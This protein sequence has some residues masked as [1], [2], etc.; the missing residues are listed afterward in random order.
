MGGVIVADEVGLGKTFVAGEILQLYRER[1]QRAVLICPAALRDS[2]WRRFLIT[3]QLFVECLSFEQLANDVQLRD[4]QR[5]NA[6]RRAPSA[7]AGRSTN[8]SSSTRPTTTAI[9]TRPPGPLRCAGS[10]SG[11][12]AIS[13]S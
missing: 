12:G 8:S 11:N 7:S 6:D 10:C 3:Y 13:C 5:P 1:R 9:P 4:A 2:T